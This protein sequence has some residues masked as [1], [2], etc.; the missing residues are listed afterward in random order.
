VHGIDALAN[1]A[2]SLLSVAMLAGVARR[3]RRRLLWRIEWTRPTGAPLD[4]S[5][6][7]GNIVQELKFDPEF[8]ERT[9]RIY[10][11][12]VDASRGADRAAGER[13]IRCSPARFRRRC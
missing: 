1:E 9:Y 8:R 10:A 12:L 5:L 11:E 2:R 13:A 7:Q 6:V 3:A 4:M